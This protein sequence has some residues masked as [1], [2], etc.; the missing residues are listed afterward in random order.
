M[1][2]TAQ[3]SPVAGDA[4][5]D[6][7]LGALVNAMWHQRALLERLALRATAAQL[8]LAG[9][10][11]RFMDRAVDELED[12]G[13]AVRRADHEPARF[14]SAILRHLGLAADSTVRDLADHLDEPWTR[15]LT[16]QAVGLER[17]ARSLIATSRD[18]RQLALGGLSN[19]R[20]LL[21]LS[22][23][24]VRGEDAG[25]YDRNGRATSQGATGLD[26]RA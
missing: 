25:T 13:R 3:S 21:A 16:E 2:A 4:V 6:A 17:V 8:V 7:G 19:V 12:A 5:L 18:N 14:L 22:A 24:G 20:A 15:T 1:T 11:H 26:R 23:G 10:D 9:D